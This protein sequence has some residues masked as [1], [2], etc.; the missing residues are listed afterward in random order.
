MGWSQRLPEPRRLE[1]RVADLGDLTAALGVTGPVVTVAHDWGG[2][3]SLGWGLAHRD[4]LR[5]LV[6]TNTAVAQPAGDVGP[7]LIRLAS[8]LR[9][10]VTVRTP[11]FVATTTRLSPPGAA[12]G[13]SGGV[14]GA[15]PDGGP[16]AVGRRLRGRHPVHADAPVPG[17]PGRR[18]E[19]DPVAGRAGAAAVGAAGPGVRRPVPGRPAV[20]AAA[21]GAAPVRGRVTP[22][23]RGRSAVRRR[24]DPVGH[25]P[26][27]PG[28]DRNRVARRGVGRR[29]GGR[30][31]G[32]AGGRRGDLAAAVV[33]AGGAGRGLLGRGG[34]GRR[35]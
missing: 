22:A 18:G 35:G 28:P 1:Q 2:V 4:Q 5:G 19:P 23:A 32:R 25:R 26:V 24:R 7:V 27:R 12:A 34:R 17:V 11:L 9:S 16:A 31:R 14:R 8:L 30:H 33:G 20:A 3:I 21:G 29:V 15:V 10:A 13:G 6:L